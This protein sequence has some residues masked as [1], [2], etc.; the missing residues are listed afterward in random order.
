MYNADFI[1]LYNTSD[2]PVDISDWSV[3]YYTAGQINAGAPTSTA[4]IPA[5]TILAPFG[6]YV[7]R[8]SP[9]DRAGAA[10][11]C[12]HLNAASSFAETGILS[13][14]GKLVLTS[15]GVDLDDCMS[16]ANV[17]DR[18]GWGNLPAFVC[19]ETDNA[20]QPFASTSVQRR[21]GETDTDNNQADFTPFSN[22][23]PCGQ[24]FA[25]T[26]AVVNV[27][28]RV[29][30]ANG[31]GISRA[32]IRMSSGEGV[33]RTTYTNAF[34]YYNFE[35]VEVGQ[36]KIIDV[37]AKRYNFTESTQVVVVNDEITNVNFVAN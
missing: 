30:N 8:I 24:L 22:P 6:F 16:T 27:G 9:A 20:G 15:N 2:A 23:T 32:L 5:A 18:I 17:M 29:T 12:E 1:E 33:T 37:Q 25:P 7:I 31:Q 21:A 3:Q 13:S 19:N 4:H 34:G 28:G 36:S 10:L 11:P 26:S 35:E 14:G